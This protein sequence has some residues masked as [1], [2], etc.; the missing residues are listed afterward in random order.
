MESSI[1][2]PTGLVCG[3]GLELL[4]GTGMG[5]PSRSGFLANIPSWANTGLRSP[6]SSGYFSSSL[7][8]FAAIWRQP[9]IVD[10]SALFTADQLRGICSLE[11][12]GDAFPP[13]LPKLG[14]RLACPGQ[15]GQAPGL[16]ASSARMSFSNFSPQ[17]PHLK[18][19]R[20]IGRRRYE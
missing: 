20:I 7:S 13:S 9:A 4:V 16:S 15:S 5:S 10:G 1:D 14:S 8:L 11:G 17:A 3:S 2:Y 19:K 6:A 12:P 18:S